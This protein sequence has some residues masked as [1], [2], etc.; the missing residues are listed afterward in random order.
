MPIEK[1]DSVVHSGWR[2]EPMP[3]ILILLPLDLGTESRQD[4]TQ[5]PAAVYQHQRIVGAVLSSTGVS[6]ST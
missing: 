5:V 4:V 6:R 3:S 1:L 2:V